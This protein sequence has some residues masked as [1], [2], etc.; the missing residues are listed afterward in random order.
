[1]KSFTLTSL[2]LGFLLGL[3]SCASL[4]KDSELSSRV[5]LSIGLSESNRHSEVKGHDEFAGNWSS[6]IIVAQKKE[7]IRKARLSTLFTLGKF[8]TNDYIVNYGGLDVP[9][10]DNDYHGVPMAVSFIADRKDKTLKK[11]RGKSKDDILI[12]TYTHRHWLNPI[13]NGAT[14]TAPYVIRKIEDPAQTDFEDTKAFEL[15]GK[16]YEV[17]GTMRGGTEGKEGRFETAEVEGMIVHVSRWGFKR[18]ACTIYVNEG[19]FQRMNKKKYQKNYRMAA[20][21]RKHVRMPKIMAMNIYAEEGCAYAEE[22]ARHLLK[23]NI[24]Y[25]KKFLPTLYYHRRIVHEIQV[26]DTESPFKKNKIIQGRFGEY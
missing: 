9:N 12:L 14:G 24:E 3:T 16:E 8:V 1:M 4:F 21:K 6:G 7:K 13:P 11:Y 26:L 2:I 23:V 25:S 15:F 18:K 17:E 22:V 20:S 10:T 5:P 19:G